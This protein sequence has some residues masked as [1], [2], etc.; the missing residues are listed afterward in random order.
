MVLRSMLA[1]IS[2]TQYSLAWQRF[3]ICVI[4]AIYTRSLALALSSSAKRRYGLGRITNLVS[5]DLGRFV[6]M[7][8]MVVDIFLIP[9]EIAFALVL[10]SHEVSYAFVAGLVV[11]GV[12]LH[13][14]TLLVR[15][16][17]SRQKASTI[18]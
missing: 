4:S 11:L 12:M 18:Q 3:D 16:L 15:R 5:V 10:F 1:S 6:S 7:P 9:A 8:C 17:L 13:V 14:Q 2:G